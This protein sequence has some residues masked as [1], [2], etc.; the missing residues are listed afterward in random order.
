L[1]H[2]AV[3]EMDVKQEIKN[4]FIRIYKENVW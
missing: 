2:S 4:A 1:R 3:G